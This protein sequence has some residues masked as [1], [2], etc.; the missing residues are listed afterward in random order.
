[1]RALDAQVAAGGADDAVFEM[2]SRVRLFMGDCEGGWDDVRRSMAFNPPE[3]SNYSQGAEVPAL[4]R[5][6]SHAALRRSFAADKTG[7]PAWFMIEA[8]DR[9]IARRPQL[10]SAW[11][12]RGTLKR[13][14]AEY[15]SAVSDFNRAEALGLRDSTLLTWRGEAKIQSLDFSGGRRDLLAALKLPCDAWNYAWCGRALLNLAH[16]RGG[17]K[18]IEKAIELAPRYGFYRAWR[19][20]AR[21]QLGRR[22]GV[23]E[24]FEAALKLDRG[25]YR[26][27]ILAWRG[28]ARLKDGRPKEALRD[29]DAALKD[30][31]DFVFVIEAKARALR[32]LGRWKDWIIC[33]DRAA[34][35]RAKHVEAAYGFSAQDAAAW[36]ADLSTVLAKSP[37]LAQ[38]R[39]WRGF[40]LTRLGRLDEARIDLDSAVRLDPRDPWGWCWRA[41]RQAAD[42]DLRGALKDFNA[43]LRLQPSIALALAGRAKVHLSLGRHD[44]ALKDFNNAALHD[45]H[46]V[47]VFTERGSLLLLLGRPEEALR[48]LRY[49]LGRDAGNINARVD[50]AVGL[51]LSGDTK[52]ARREARA[53][54]HAGR[55]QAAARL[56]LWAGMWKALAG[57]RGWAL[58]H[59]T[60]RRRRLSVPS[61]SASRTSPA[62]TGPTP[63]GVPV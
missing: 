4:F 60:R 8:L 30:Q 61:R 46:C 38:A 20:L 36:I 13:H 39:R 10:A 21:L 40:F 5:R 18:Y 50:F 51:N 49:A 12:W 29:F 28:V 54:A 59:P 35:L 33:F 16:D 47:S 17:L 45:P 27:E 44:L 31:P 32:R 58:G 37:R 43:S 57:R 41:E 48:D 56:A 25:L 9:I 55:D 23:Y 52:A 14:F 24:D 63:A 7:K 1:L 22:E 3:S 15:A 19:G 6:P 26:P 53:A 42:G 11:I 62:A 2:R 34:H